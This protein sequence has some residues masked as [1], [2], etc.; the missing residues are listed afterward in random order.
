MT[1][2]RESR[3]FG[4]TL[5][6]H[7]IEV[8][9][10]PFDPAAHADTFELFAREIIPPGGEDLP[11][12]LYLQGGP[13]F[14]APRPAEPAGVIAKALERYR[15]VL[16]DQRGTGRSHRID[17]RSP[18]VDRRADRL[19]LLRQEYIVSDAE[20]LRE[21]LGLKR[22]S[23]FGQS[24]G[25][26][27]I[28]TY[29]S[30]CPDS[31]DRAFLTGG[32]PSVTRGVADVYRSTYGKLAVR[33]ERFFRECPWAESRIAEIVDHLDNSDERLPT[34]ERLSSRRFRTIGIELGRGHGF[35]TLAYL[36]E[37]PFRVVRGEKFLKTDFLADV[38]SRVSFEDGPL[39][40]TIHESIYGGVAG[41]TQTRWAAH[42]VREE[43]EEFAEETT[44]RIFLTGEHIYPW[45]FQED[46][47]LH[48]FADAA[49]ELAQRSWERSPYDVAALGEAQAVA[50]AAI[51]VDDIFVPFEESLETAAA[52]RD[53]RPM[54]TNAFQ[55]NGIAHDG[56]GIMSELM[57]LAD[58]H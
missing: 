50:S 26:F 12:L 43:Y 19:A 40:A 23:L 3:R 45:Q 54:I 18:A 53:L 1:A 35:D 9:W 22:W 39:Y 13:G 17:R 31:V 44:G 41:H 49:E 47:A 58:D 30:M 16:M 20:S 36:L 11:V 33:H 2:I 4:H 24:F 46:P 52:Y 15:V 5:R 25:G 42:R 28:T 56:K 21:H 32:L 51:Y 37:D 10:D 8:P 27:C 38:G 48:A 55:H 34:G 6:E 7:V 29:L 14:P 57:R